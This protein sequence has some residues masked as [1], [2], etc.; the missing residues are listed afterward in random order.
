[1]KP[2][3]STKRLKNFYKDSRTTNPVSLNWLQKRLSR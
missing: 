3:Q 2:K 1:M